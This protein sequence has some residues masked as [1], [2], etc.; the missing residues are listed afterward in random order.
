MM[1]VKAMCI[2]LV[3]IVS[4]GCAKNY[5]RPL[6]PGE[7]ALRKI[8]DP[9]MIPDFRPAFHSREGLVESID[10]SLYYYTHPSSQRFFPYGKGT[11]DISHERAVRS[12]EM[13]KSVL[14][15]ATSPD[16]FQQ[17][18]VNEFDVYIS[19][20]CDGRGTVLFTGYCTPIYDASLTPTAEYRYP[21]YK[22]PPDLVKTEDGRIEGR[23]TPSGDIVPYYTRA[24]IER[25]DL[26][27]GHELV[28]LK[29][30]LEAYFVHVQGS[31][32]LRMPD[33]TFYEVGYAGKNGRSYTSLGE[34]LKADRKIHPDRMSLT[35]IKEYFRKN[36]QDL[37]K[38]LQQN[39]SYVFF[40]EYPGGP[41]GSLGGPVT[42]YR[43][44]ATDKHNL[45][46]EHNPPE[47]YPRG[48]LAF[49]T[50]TLPQLDNNRVVKRPYRGF[51]L[52]QDTG[53]AIRSA[54]RADVYMGTGD[55]AEHLA[56]HTMSEGKIYYLF[57]RRALFGPE[58]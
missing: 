2:A 17:R 53:G 33:G 47:I 21:L 11:L 10:N 51:I 6:P 55:L 19:V 8:N 13:F 38:Y 15:S 35:G 16:D 29:D 1:Y 41:Q 4:H 39:D 42:A 52:D 9:K 58:M 31:A 3:M 40:M 54:G 37:D 23:R 22:L 49:I 18:I 48:A 56:G 34:L 27:R 57:V 44:I 12:L 45:T 43:S 24:E 20:G 14:E 32:R 46:D 28:Y 25:G 36:P 26:L 5:S 30:K 50:T 7:V